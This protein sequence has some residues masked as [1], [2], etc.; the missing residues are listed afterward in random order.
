MQGNMFPSSPFVYYY[1]DECD[2][3]R[4]ANRLKRK[5]AGTVYFGRSLPPF[6]SVFVLFR[7]IVGLFSCVG[8]SCMDLNR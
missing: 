4:R 1:D 8:K 2:I 6:S 7:N 3:K 5:V